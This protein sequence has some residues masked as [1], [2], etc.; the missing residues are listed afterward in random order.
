M[1]EYRSR[2][3][4]HWHMG[5]LAAR[6]VAESGIPTDR[7]HL[8]KLVLRSLQDDPD[9]TM[10]IDGA[11][12]GSITN[13]EIMRLS[14]ACATSYRN[15]GVGLGDVVAIMSPSNLHLSV[16]FYAGLFTGVVIAPVD[17]T[18]GVPEIVNT[19][20]IIQPK[21][22][23]CTGNSAPNI[24]LAL[25]E[26]ESN[27]TIV[28]FDKSDY[29]CSLEE[30]IEKYGD[31]DEEFKVTDFDATDASVLL[32]STSGTT[33]LP[34]AAETTH[35]N[36]AISI[37]YQWAQHQKFPSPVRMTLIGA[38][39]QWL[40]SIFQYISTPIFRITRLESSVPVTVDLACELINKYKPAYTILSPTIMTT[41]VKTR[42][43]CELTCFKQ[44][45]LGGSAVSN[46]LFFRLQEVTPHTLLCNG[47][48]MTELCGL[49]LQGIMTDRGNFL[50]ALGCFQYRIVNPET[51]EEI[52]EP[53]V[54]GELWLKG[55]TIFKGY[56]RNEAAT[57][58]TF[59]GDGW[60]KTGDMFVRDERWYYSFVERIKLLLKYKSYQ[61][62]PVE[63]ENV[64]RKHPG[65][66]DVAV[67]GIRDDECGDL[68]VACVVP[69]PG[70]DTTIAAEIKDI[71]KASLSDAK[72]LRGG[73]VFLDAIPVT[74][75]TK[76]H[77]RKLKELV[78]VL[79]KY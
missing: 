48:G 46:D 17:S 22:I 55:P 77:R 9:F 24:Q 72:Q 63:V 38:P 19:F 59:S 68:P 8:G 33:G 52:L 3:W 29:L 10:Q 4:V 44:M 74:A 64:I 61:I 31:T 34:K 16:P 12:G 18:L 40:T 65:V 27:A 42:K 73:V 79:D 26:M 56:Y 11:T 36:F 15:V 58:E 50:T 78:Q 7:Y 35:K 21:M 43:D 60:F 20:N 71:V 23:F 2:D 32:I 75:T 66:L 41:L 6:V 13:G 39:L 28:T 76:V 45:L 51:H 1:S 14:M 30:F 37:A 25:N 5:E 53:N 47:F 67:T 70:F 62:S 54:P 57:R 49:G 69:R